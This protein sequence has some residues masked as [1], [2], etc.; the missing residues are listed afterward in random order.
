M[1]ALCKRPAVPKEDKEDLIP[2]KQPKVEA[3]VPRLGKP[4]QG[5][6]QDAH[7]RSR[8][9]ELGGAAPSD[10]DEKALKAL[11]SS[12]ARRSVM[13]QAELK[14]QARY[15]ANVAERNRRAAASK[16]REAQRAE[17]AG[18]E[19]EALAW[20]RVIR[21]MMRHVSEYTLR[22]STA[23]KDPNIGDLW[24]DDEREV[25]WLRLW[26]EATRAIILGKVSGHPPHLYCMCMCMCPHPLYS[27]PHPHSSPSLLTL[28]PHFAPLLLAQ[29]EPSN[30]RADQ[31]SMC[32]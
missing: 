24:T 10:A 13:N 15:D 25:E 16:A 19:K 14:Q 9:A 27:R 11:F 12:L 7:L 6:S 18:A 30:P 28:T 31:P 32:L 17:M 26:R 23:I 4:P 22:L 1:K 3:E 8:I 21:S 20:R 2:V 5:S 29:G